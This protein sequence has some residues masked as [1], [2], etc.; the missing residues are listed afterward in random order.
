MVIHFCFHRLCSV[1]I[2]KRNE[3]GHGR[4]LL[5]ITVDNNYDKARKLVIKPAINISGSS[6]KMFVI[7]DRF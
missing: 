1:C 6:C 5:L 3:A 2:A 7:L 4:L